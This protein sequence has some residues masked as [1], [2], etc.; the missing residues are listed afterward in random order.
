MIVPAMWTEFADFMA[1]I[2]VCR[3]WDGDLEAT[4]FEEDPPQPAAAHPLASIAKQPNTMRRMSLSSPDHTLEPA[5][6]VI[7]GADRAD[8]VAGSVWI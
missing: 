1:A 6:S 2:A 5:C 3:I 8:F 4:P 7:Q